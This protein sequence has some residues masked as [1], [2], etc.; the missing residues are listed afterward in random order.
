MT[1]AAPTTPHI[2]LLQP[3]ERWHKSRT[4]ILWN[5]ATQA[6]AAGSRFPVY[7]FYSELLSVHGFTNVSLLYFITFSFFSSPPPPTSTQAG[8]KSITDHGAAEEV[9]VTLSAFN[10]PRGSMIWSLKLLLGHA[11]WLSCSR[12]KNPKYW[13]S[14]KL[15][16]TL[17]AE[18]AFSH[19]PLHS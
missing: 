12:Y 17:V 7:S 4:N 6:D 1:T 8:D 13:L 5:H 19:F 11:A 2:T 10:N 9:A 16:P 18:E 14:I 3:C 15:R